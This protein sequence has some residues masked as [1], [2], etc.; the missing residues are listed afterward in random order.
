MSQIIYVLTNEAMPG[1][2]KIGKTTTHLEQRIRDLSSST[3]V[4]LPFTPYYACTVENATFV[5]RQLHDA[6][7]DNRVNP[8]CEFFAIDPERVVAALK[9]AQIEDITPGHDIVDSPEDQ[10]ALDEARQIRSRF[11]F[12]MVGIPLGATLYFSRD[13]TVTAKVIGRTGSESIEFNG[14]PMSLSAAAQQALGYS[15]VVAGTDYWSYEGETLDE[16]RRRMEED[17]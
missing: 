16:R 1:Y 7:G 13:E 2:V 12:D 10:R 11:N 15:N 3:S 9:L 17:E 4:P 14:T 8:K 5:E 6:F